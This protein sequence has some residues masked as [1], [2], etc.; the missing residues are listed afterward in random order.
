MPKLVVFLNKCDLVDDEELLELVEMEVNCAFLCLQCLFVVWV[1]DVAVAS[2]SCFSSMA[3][4][5]FVVVAL[6]LH[7]TR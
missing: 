4:G 3:P 7:S 2:C 6:W 5:W 1:R